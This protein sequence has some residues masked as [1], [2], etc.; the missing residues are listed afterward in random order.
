MG[1]RT[2]FAVSLLTLLAAASAGATPVDCEPARCAVQAAIDE[3]CPCDGASNHG[4]YVSCVARLV[5]KMA[6]E[7]DSVIPRGCKGKIRRCAARSTCGKPGFVA[8]HIPTDTCDLTTSTCTAD[9]TK[10]CTTDVDCGARCRIKRSAEICALRGGVVGA[11]A[12]C[13]AD[14]AP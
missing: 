4:R 12:T 11:S 14:C 5:N 10:S 13:C 7:P 6:R 3:Q 2:A 8:C 9:A 1:I